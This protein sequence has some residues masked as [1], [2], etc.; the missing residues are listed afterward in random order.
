MF[1]VSWSGNPSFSPLLGE[2][3]VDD[4]TQLECNITGLTSVSFC[5]RIVVVVVFFHAHFH[6]LKHLQIPSNL[7][8]KCSSHILS[9]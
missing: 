9:P 7:Q 8:I 4:A 2:M 1:E 5:R 3:I 6:E